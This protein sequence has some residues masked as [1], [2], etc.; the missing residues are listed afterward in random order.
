MNLMRGLAGLTVSVVL[1]A[2]CDGQRSNEASPAP[3]PQAVETP[4]PAQAPAPAVDTTPIVDPN[5]MSQ[6]LPEGVVL[7]LAV[8]P[9]KDVTMPRKNGKRPGRRV[10]FEILEGDPATA[11]ASIHASMLEAG[12]TVKTGPTTEGDT[13]REVF[14]KKNYGLVHAR[15]DGK[16]PKAGFVDPTAKGFAAMAW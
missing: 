15:V 10:E 16:A 5:P 2:G 3:A 13:V 11:M 4:K 12:F 8:H 7:K 6:P 14:S 1:L 9:L